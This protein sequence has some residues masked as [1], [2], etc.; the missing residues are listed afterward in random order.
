MSSTDPTDDDG[1][2]SRR[3]VLQLSTSALLAGIAGCSTVLEEPVTE[4][5]VTTGTRETD[6]TST[7]SFEGDPTALNGPW[8]TANADA[9]NTRTVTSPGPRGSGSVRWEEHVSLRTATVATPGPDGPVATQRNGTVL[10]YDHDGRLRWRRHHG[11]GF[12][13][14]PVVAPDG[15]VVVG[16]R[17]GRVVAYDSTGA[18]LWEQST[19][20]G[21]FAPHANDATP[22]RIVGDTVLLAH[23]RMRLFAFDL[24][25]GTERFAVEIPPRSHRPAVDDGRVF[26]TS[27]RTRERRGGVVVARSLA[28]GSEH[29]RAQTDRPIHIGAGVHD[30]VVY[31]ADIDGGFVAW[32]ASDGSER[33]R[34]RIEGEPWLSTIPVVFGGRVWVGTL[35]EGLYGLTDAGVQVHVDVDTATTPAVG[36]GRLYVGSSDFGTQSEN[37][38]GSVVALAPDG[39]ELWRATTRGW[40]DAQVHY[41]D[42]TVT[43]GT[44]TGVVERFDASTG[45]R[46]WRAFAR[47]DRLPEPSVG[48]GTVYCG[49]L[50][51][52][53][54]GYRV[55]D[56]TSHLWNVGFEGTSRGTP[57]VVGQ[58]VIAGSRSGE[59]AGTPLLEYTEA[60]GGRLTRTP[61]PDD[62]RPTSHIDAPVPDP[63]WRTLLGGPVG[64]VGYGTEAAYL[65][66]GRRVVSITSGGDV[67]WETDVGGRV[68]GA[69][70]VVDGRVYAST[71]G[72]TVVAL[73][74]DDGT[75]EWRR[76]VGDVATAPAV[77]RASEASL[78]VVGT[79][80]AVVAL[81]TTDG[82]EQWRASTGF[83]RGTPAVTD[84]L[85]IAGD[86]SGALRGLSLSDG[87][88]RWRVETDGPIHGAPAV[89]DRTAYVGS[90]DRHLYAVSTRDGAVEWRL[91]LTDWV[92]GSPAVAYGVVFVVDQSGTLSAVVG[93]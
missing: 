82:S 30:G 58:T 79:G 77:T 54:G 78:A 3:R 43:L 84:G 72:G 92:D 11:A 68:R 16:S 91:E 4:E 60:P 50:G 22:F 15:T 55:T 36:D 85:A 87:T 75:E 1:A 21:L 46:Q 59:V 69:P 29:W 38:S 51:D 47:P 63:R 28:D 14:S 40:P 34:V 27:G 53:V 76:S 12:A 62:D 25:D 88:E 24:A 8:P 33:W 13:A 32:D 56:G 66:S 61:T 81:A 86:G 57:T 5:P 83:V 70:A 18:R 41:R 48:P 2:A 73:T 67:R 10:A 80:S 44:D 71:A 26:L 49:S 37:E 20:R 39:S 17:D 31:S 7:T 93:E 90:R 45:A 23:P 89:A 35:S 42:G 64:D 9:A 65:G 52:N 19:P 74:A 6:V